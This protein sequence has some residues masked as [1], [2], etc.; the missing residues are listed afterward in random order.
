MEEEEEVEEKGKG[1]GEGEGEG[2]GGECL[3]VLHLLLL[4]GHRLELLVLALLEDRRLL[5]A[6]ASWLG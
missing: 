6:H 5:L 2:E 4:G 3:H 1:E